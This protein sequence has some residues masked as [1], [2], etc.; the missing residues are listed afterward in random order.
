MTSNSENESHTCAASL[1]FV[2]EMLNLNQPMRE[3]AYYSMLFLAAMVFGYSNVSL[4]E[5]DPYLR[6]F[7]CVAVSE[8]HTLLYYTRVVNT[9]S[10]ASVFY[11]AA[12]FAYNLPGHYVPTCCI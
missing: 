3:I 4:P 11:F 6:A 8:L 9:L 10:L 7:E 1:C 5:N 12:V 2:S